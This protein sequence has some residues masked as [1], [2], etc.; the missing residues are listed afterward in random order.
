[1]YR[2]EASGLNS[3]RV[4]FQRNGQ[5]RQN[6]TCVLALDERSGFIRVRSSFFWCPHTVQIEQGNEEFNHQGREL[7]YTNSRVFFAIPTPTPELQP[8]TLL[9]TSVLTWGHPGGRS[10]Q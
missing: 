10:W 9:V 2:Q 4:S 3:V 5:T 8:Q 1:M 6:L 7:G